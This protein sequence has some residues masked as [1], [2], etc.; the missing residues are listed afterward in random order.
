MPPGIK[1]QSFRI[2]MYHKNPKSY[3]DLLIFI[4]SFPGLVVSRSSSKRS[5]TMES[6]LKI[7]LKAFGK[8]QTQSSLSPGNIHQLLLGLGP[9]AEIVFYH[10]AESKI[11]SFASP[12]YHD[13]R[14]TC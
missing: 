7:I 8:F 13:T 5:L 4:F 14:E 11:L 6:E 9:S 1:G 12:G 3:L 2:C 10:S